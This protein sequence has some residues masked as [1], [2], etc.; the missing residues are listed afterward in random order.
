[1][2]NSPD[3]S[4][5]VNRSLKEYSI[6]S[7]P[8]NLEAAKRG[9]PVQFRNPVYGASV[10]FLGT[11][12]DSQGN[13]HLTVFAYRTYPS[14]A[15]EYCK[16]FINGSFDRSGNQYR[17]QDIVMSPRKVTIWQLFP[18]HMFS[19]RSYSTS[20]YYSYEELCAQYPELVTDPEWRVVSFEL[21]E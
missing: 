3:A 4:A 9:E 15:E 5:T 12:L 16:R 13:E 7:K 14:S 1:M 6:M 18:R 8:F 11:L 2:G 20:A 10:R 17:E 21:E 19:G